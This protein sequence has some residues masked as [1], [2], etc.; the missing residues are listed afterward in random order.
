MNIKKLSLWFIFLIVVGVILGY[1]TWHQWNANQG[2]IIER[3]RP[4]PPVAEFMHGA[5]IS[6]IVFS[7]ADQDIIATA[8]SDNTIKI[9]NRNSPNTP[10]EIQF[11][12]EERLFSLDYLKNGELLL[13]RGLHRKTGLWN[14]LSNKMIYL[15]QEKI[16][17][18]TAI[19]PSADKIATVH[20]QRVVL[21]NIEKPDEPSIITEIIELHHTKYHNSFKC[22]A[23]S[24]NE[25]TLAIGY[26]NGDIRIW[27]LEQEQFTKTLSVSIDSHVDLRRI[28]FSPDGRWIATREHFNLMLWDTYNKQ[29]HVLL[30]PHQGFLRDVKFSQ[31]G[32]FIGIKTDD[33]MG[34][35]IIWSLPEVLI[36]HQMSY[37]QVSEGIISRIAF[38]PDDKILAVSNHREV[39]LLSLETLTPIAILKGKGFFGGAHEITFSSDATM[40]AGGT[41]GGIIRLWD[42]SNIF[43]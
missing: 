7:S 26:E 35:Y 12:S 18:D 32:R 27:D 29:R 28:K 15:L 21:W 2:T 39:T 24:N 25:K 9:W 1:S 31:D 23:F 20:S 43:D 38:S 30:E 16:Q 19:S 13:C 8:G 34:G 3:M 11:D 14:T 22:A 41:F 33:G 42:V 37:Q 36:Y 6:D 40:L 10:T 4:I 17:W 5:R